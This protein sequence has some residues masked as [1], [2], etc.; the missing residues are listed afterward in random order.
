MTLRFFFGCAAAILAALELR[1][2]SAAVHGS[3]SGGNGNA[4]H[5][6]QSQTRPGN[7]GEEI[8]ETLPSEIHLIKGLFFLF[9]RLFTY[10]FI[11]GIKC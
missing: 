9:D 4:G 3:N 6:I 1:A 2:T 10:L 7:G 8:C 11:I 5:T